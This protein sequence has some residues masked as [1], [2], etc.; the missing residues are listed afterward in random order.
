MTSDKKAILLI[1]DGL[2]D[3]PTPKTPLQTAKKPN[4]DKLAKDGIT[5]LMSTIGRGIVP[6]SDTGHL[7][8]LGYEP[9]EYYHGRGPLE[10]LGAGIALRN[11]DI[12]FRAN[13]ATAKGNNI[14]DRRAGRLETTIAKRLES[15]LNFEIEDVQCIFKST[16]EHRG[17]L[18]L[19][20]KGLSANISETDPHKNDH[21]LE[22]KPLDDSKEAKKTAAVVNAFTRSARDHLHVHEDNRKR[23]KTGKP[24]ANA[25]LLRGAGAYVKVPT[26]TERFGITATCVA[27]GALYKGV[28]KYIGMS[29]LNVDGAT[30]T[31]DTN[32]KEKGKATVNALRG[33]D[34][35]F[36]HVKG[37]D[38]FGHDG[39]FNGKTKMIE[40]ID[41]ELI[42][43][44]AKSGANLIITGDHSTPCI[45]KGHS[46]HEVPILIHGNERADEV[47]T[48]DEQSCMGGGLGHIN[49][50][51]IMPII[52]N[53]I[54]KA[55]KYGS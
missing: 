17:V 41:A 27:G 8:L 19:R 39:D 10:A 47:K 3:L 11:G 33:N 52:L 12:A 55:K 18:V 34:L 50:K 53:L 2:G 23:E 44:I 37:C 21:I 28:A 20:G 45:I 4:L 6:G 38:S 15:V 14:V 22:S 46:G 26:I 29:V 48:F 24:E 32:L 49:G 42:P 36:L 54:G 30:G 5:G 51:D 16:V 7:Q 13:F 43:I 1:I 31:A 35:V 40:R 9:R 25:V